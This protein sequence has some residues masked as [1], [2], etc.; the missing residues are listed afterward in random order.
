MRKGRSL[1][2]FV[3]FYCRRPSTDVPGGVVTLTRDDGAKREVWFCEECLADVNALLRGEID[4]GRSSPRW[5][6]P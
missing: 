1:F 6:W 2:V 5:P 4:E 3:C